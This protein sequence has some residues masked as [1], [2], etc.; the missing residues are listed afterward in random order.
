MPSAMQ[1]LAPIIGRK[2]TEKGGGTDAAP[3]SLRKEPNDDDD[4]RFVKE[5]R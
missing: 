2:G 4:E 1:N 3:A 5:I